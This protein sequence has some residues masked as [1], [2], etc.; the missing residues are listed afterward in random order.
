MKH[1]LVFVFTII[2]CGA[3]AQNLLSNSGFETFTAGTSSYMTTGNGN[4]TGLSGQWQLAFSGNNFPT[5]SGASCGTTLIDNTTANSGANSL[6]LNITKH[7]S[8]NNIRLFQSI[9]TIGTQNNFVVTF[10]MKSDI[11][12]YPV[13]VNVFKSTEAINSNGA[14]NAASPCQSYT[15]TTGWKQYKMIVDLSSWNTSERTNM[16]ISIRPNTGISSAAPSGTYPKIFWIDDVTFN[17]IDNNVSQK[18]DVALLKDIAIQVANER[19]QLA[20]DSGF[21]AEANTLANEIITLASSSPSPITPTKAIGFNP[22]PTQTTGATNPF[23]NALH[24]WA[25]NYLTQS[26]TGFPKATTDKSIFPTSYDL[27]TVGT[28]LENLHWLIVSPYSAFQYNPELFR[29]FL[30][31]IYATSDDY[32][33]NGSSFSSV[34]G[35]TD[36]AADDWF[37]APKTCYSWYMGDLSFGSY[38]PPFLRQRLKDAADTIGTNFYKRALAEVDVFLYVNRDVSYAETLIQAGVYRNNNAWIN[39]GKRIV[40]SINLVNRLP[41]GA[42][43]YRII[44]NEVA[45]YHGGN[46]NSLAK[47]WSMVEYQPAWD[48]VSKTAMYELLSVEPREVAEFYTAAAWKTQWN[49]SAGISAEPLLAITKNQYLKTRYNQFRVV[50]GYNDEMVLSLSYYNPNI[51]SLPLVDNY[52]V[53]DRNI[54]GVRGR[55][56]RFSYGFTGRQVARPGSDDTGLQTYIGAMETKT[57]R[58]ANEDELDASLFVVHS[59]VHVKNSSKPTQWTDWAYMNA[60]IDSKVCAA[61]NASTL[62]SPSVLQYQTGGPRGIETNWA[63]YQQW[64]T[65]PD[66][67]IGVVETYPKNN[68]AAQAFEID[69]RVRF[70][71]GRQTLQSPKYMVTE[72]AGSKYSYGKFK[73]IIHGHDFTTVSVDSAGVVRDDDYGN[74]MEIIFRYNL[75]TGNTLYTYPATTKKYFIV[76]IRDSM[77]V[78]DANVSRVING[79]I[80]GLVVKLNGKSYASYR[81]DGTATSVDLSTV[82]INGNTNQVHFSR[83]DSSINRPINI[84]GTSYTIPA[85]EQV[86]IISTNTPATDTG[87]GWQNYPELLAKEGN[88]GLLPV[89]LVNFSGNNTNAVSYLNWQTATEINADEFVVEKSTDGSSFIKMQTVNAICKNGCAYQT[90]IAQ[91]E[92]LAY[93]RLRIIDKDGTFTYSQTIAIKS[94]V[95]NNDNAIIVNPNPITGQSFKVTV[96]KRINQTLILKFIDSNGRIVHQQTV[97]ANTTTLQ[98]DIKNKKLSSG[99]YTVQLV[100]QGIKL[101]NKFIVL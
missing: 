61:R 32:K 77:A 82:V 15:T 47:I 36:Q 37:A 88:Y 31:I 56:G 2:F 6:K 90:N 26:F 76:E 92:E 29:R 35:T 84:T 78:G 89:S 21:T 24:N 4:A 33:L 27:R 34:P 1:S 49:G 54:K 94:N 12:G 96:V 86:L 17:F 73:T 81:N 41:D 46:N 44:Q 101:T 65:L 93:Y 28:T 14:C 79:N 72:V 22:A 69:G 7:T 20:Q 97:P 57:G 25:A 40:D 19:K 9:A 48:C 59:K 53:Y 45:N 16:R 39:M 42:Y 74:S 70:T 80:K 58:N 63:S 3:Q 8:R 98:I 38:I 52:M 60:R 95:S 91:P 30:T 67:I 13:T 11:A 66:R 85:N 23:I 62:S 5:C 51:A 87:R 10:Y 83:G 71:Y 68:L 75:S 43:N 99:Q 50:D 55:Y 100:G 64:I 18:N